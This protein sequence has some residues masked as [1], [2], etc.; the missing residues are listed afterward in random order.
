MTRAVLV[1]NSLKAD[2]DR[3]RALRDEVASAC[4]AAGWPEPEVR[5]TTDQDPGTAAARDAVHQGA[6]LVVACGGDG[7]VNAV[8]EALADT[9][10]CL[11]IVPLGTGNLLAANLGIPTAIDE[12][13]SVLIH[14]TNQVIDLG[15]CGERVFT[16][17]AGLGLDA[18]MVADAP[19]ALKKRIG[20]PAYLVPIVRHLPDRGVTLTLDLDGRRV[21]HHRVR[22]MLV[23]NI[24]RVHGGL[25]LLPDADPQDG[26]L[27]L[28]VLAPH[29]RLLGWLPVLARLGTG[30]LRGSDTIF[31][32][33]AGRV[34]ARTDRAVD[35]EL[36]GEPYRR[37]AVLEIEVRPGALLVRVPATAHGESET[38]AG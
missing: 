28:A 34:V 31:T 26:I 8:A 24:G 17:I 16:G 5:M 21:R 27:D 32:Y 3:V 19:D 23:G 37:A 12:A 13:I 18:A 7:T 36:D 6:E 15:S 38:R 14:G 20:W 30:R 4:A 33:R 10:V 22:T 9:G 25:D 11:G 1:V 29:G 35:Q 2:A